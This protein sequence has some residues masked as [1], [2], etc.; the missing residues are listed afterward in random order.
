MAH[1]RLSRHAGLGALRRGRDTAGHGHDTAESACDTPEESCDMTRSAR[2][3]WP[4][5]DAAIQSLY[6]E[7][8]GPWVVIK[9]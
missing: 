7:L 8:G 2:A 1:S 5:E 9:K 6:R 3:A 4:G